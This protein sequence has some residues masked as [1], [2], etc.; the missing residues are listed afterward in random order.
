MASLVAH[1]GMDAS[2]EWAKGVVANMARDPVGGDRDQIKAVA[3]GECDLA[4]VNTYYLAM[5]ATDSDDATREIAESV[6]VLWPNQ[7]G[8]GSHINIS[9]AG[10]TAHAPHPEHARQL[11]EFL[12]SDEAQK[13]YAE[14]NHEYPVRDGIPVSEQLQQ[15]GEFQRDDLNLSVLGERNAD[16]VK[17]MDRAGWQ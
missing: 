4:V 14:T 6:S 3:A 7:D 16:A 2:E 13:W 9:G 17:V 5:M 15:W 10:V 11:L 8:R 1:E 12:T